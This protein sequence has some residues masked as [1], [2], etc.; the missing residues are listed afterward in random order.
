MTN[1]HASYL[2]LLIVLILSQLSGCK[3]TDAFYPADASWDCSSAFATD[4]TG[5]SGGGGTG[6]TPN[7]QCDGN[8]TGVVDGCNVSLSV[9]DFFD[10]VVVNLS[11][12]TANTRYSIVIKDPL[13]AQVN[14]VPYIASSDGDGVIYRATVIQNLETSPRDPN[15]LANYGTYSIE[16]M[17]AGGVTPVQTLTY[18]VEEQSRVRCGT[19]TD[20]TIA[21]WSSKAS[22]LTTE[23]VYAKIQQGSGVLAD[24]DYTV[25]V[26]T[27][28]QEPLPNG[29]PL[30]GTE[31]T[32][33][34][35]GG[36]G[37]VDLGTHSTGGYDV[38]VDVDGNGLYNRLTD[39]VSRHHRINPCF[40]VQAAN[41]GS[42]I[43]GQQIASDRV[44]NKREI[45]DPNANKAVIRDVFAALIPAQQSSA[46]QP[47]VADIH[48]VPHQDLWTDSDV[49]VDQTVGPKTTP[50]QDESD[51]EATWLAWR[52][53]NLTPGCYDIA[54]DVNR[55]GVLD[56][57]TDFVDNIDH[58]GRTSTCGLRVAERGCTNVTIT[59][60]SD[61]D[62]V[63][64][65]AITLEGAITAPVGYTLLE[66]FTT[67]TSGMQSNTITLTPQS[68]GTYSLNMP[69]FNGDNHITVWAVYQN[70]ADATITISCAKTITIISRTDLALFRAQLTW[71]GSTD[72]DLHL[73]RP[74]GAYSNGGGGS[75]DCNWEN[76]NVG[77]DGL[78]T[79]SIDWG[80]IDDETDDPKLDVDCIACGNG[81]ENIW[82]N[83]ISEDG[84]Y[85]V[86]VDAFNGNETGGVTVS[87]YIRG[88]NVATVNCGAMSSGTPTDSC[89]VG[90]IRWRGG[91]AGAGTFTP[92]ATTSV[93]Y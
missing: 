59:S 78:G 44:G 72:M 64:S 41:T 83:Q 10:P 88:S 81:I 73:V 56:A 85:E 68:D 3:E 16:V 23:K 7:P 66:S 61:G 84:D 54:L 2:S 32:V 87:I 89:F 17:E 14:T 42:V 24:G 90:T 12:L 9:V 34:I 13:S 40:A 80:I 5:D 52:Y 47:G 79:N 8:D 20:A 55:N 82:M 91:S 30:A 27:D 43:D 48:V 50:V 19:S 58:L 86:Y 46:T 11:G 29:A 45:F 21:T 37:M 49:L 75:D 69:L 6:V 92:V 18:D 77:L 74:G 36:E 51:S 1:K 76:C 62:E 57:G 26:V 15:D 4:C 31:F 35:T 71:D 53:A 93:N 60:H 33:T 25:Y 70:D 65:T 28:Q 67:V 63:T 39:I 22:F 38:I